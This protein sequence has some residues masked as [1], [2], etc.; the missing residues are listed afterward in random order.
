MTFD[1][2]ILTVKTRT[3]TAANSLMPVYSY[4]QKAQYFFGFDYVGYNRYFEAMKAQVQIEHVVNVPEWIDIDGADVV[5]LEDGV[6]YRLAQIQRTW[7][8]DGL[9][10]TKLSLERVKNVV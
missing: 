7:N 10:I 8:E 1:D 6:M 3:N 2:G 4:T 9:K 5:E